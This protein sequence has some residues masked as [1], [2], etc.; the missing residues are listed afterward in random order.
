MKTAHPFYLT[1]QWRAKR[2][3][4]IKRDQ[5]RCVWCGRD[6]RGKGEAR[7]DHIVPISQAWHMRLTD[8]NLRT[9]C[10]RCDNQRHAEKGRGVPVYG[11]DA[12]GHP[13][14]PAH[15]WNK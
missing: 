11:S 5:Y 7:V 12:H 13:R 1:P 2:A 6:V 10:A 14:D 8:S 4:I 9:L 3:A 15:W